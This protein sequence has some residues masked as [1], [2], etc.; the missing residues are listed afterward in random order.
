MNKI[1]MTALVAGFIGAA[2]SAYAADNAQPVPCVPPGAAGPVDGRGGYGMGPG[3]RHAR[4]NMQQALAL[5]ERQEAKMNELRQGFFQEGA[6]LM[7]ELRT[8]RHDLA[9]ESVRNRPDERKIADLTEQ[10]GRQHARLAALESR[11]L[12]KLSSVLSHKQIETMIRM[13]DNFQNRGWKRG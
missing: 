4:P 2:G 9:V 6:P 7:Q 13:K 5:N 12:R 1:L 8:L 3:A 11:H 10:I